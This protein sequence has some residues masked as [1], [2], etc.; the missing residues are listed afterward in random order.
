MHVW[1]LASSWKRL[2]NCDQ[3]S[4]WGPGVPEPL[5]SPGLTL[6]PGRR[7]VMTQHDSTSVASL[8]PEP[9]GGFQFCVIHKYQ[10]PRNCVQRSVSPAH[11]LHSGL[12]GSEVLALALCRAAGLPGGAGGRGLGVPAPVWGEQGLVLV[13][14]F[15]LPV[16]HSCPSHPRSRRTFS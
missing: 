10:S 14:S 11:F 16:G 4:G 7:A 8:L 12:P 13:D 15:E 2:S 3:G 1:V 5:G 9:L 6:T